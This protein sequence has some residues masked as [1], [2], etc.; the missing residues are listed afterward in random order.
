MESG[1]AGMN[2]S[3]ISWGGSGPGQA[4]QIGLYDDGLRV[5]LRV[6]INGN[7]DPAYV[8]SIS[9]ALDYDNWHHI[10]VV[11]DYGSDTEIHLY[12]DGH[13]ESTVSVPSQ[14]LYSA[15]VQRFK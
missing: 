9:T 7:N 14:R 3:I 1:T 6:D 10:A 5:G 15:S 13:E 11:I 2:Q 4:R 8:Y 12:I